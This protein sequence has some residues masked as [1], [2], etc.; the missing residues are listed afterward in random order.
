MKLIL[1]PM[2]GVLDP[3]LRDLLGKIGGWDMAITEFIRVSTTVFPDHVFYRFCPE[4]H[5]NSK[6]LS[7]M[8]VRIQLL[9][10]DPEL[11]ALN[12]QRAVELGSFGIDLNFGCP[13]KTVNRSMGGAILLKDT[14]ILYDIVKA[15]RDAV[16]DHLPVTAKMRLGYEDDCKAMDNAVAMYEAGA[17]ELAIHAR[18]KTDGYRPPAYWKKIKPI[19]DALPINV[20][21]NGEI[22]TKEQAQQCQIES[23]CEDIMM[24][25]GA[26][27]VP[28]LAKVILGEDKMPWNEVLKWLVEYSQYEVSLELVSYYPN[29]LKQWLT[30][31]KLAYPEAQILFDQ[32]KRE[33][34]R[35]SITNFVRENLE[36]IDN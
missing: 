19:A 23:G 3:P 7:G 9:G 27:A 25:R 28:N 10:N 1:A 4:L 11:V 29:R 26:L 31:L 32:I 30:F 8:P 12:A 17:S 33:K 24:G 16:P 20:I 5:N 18:T 36:K 21:A 14:Q 2:E 34:S 13:A 6:T 15:V 35:E 22:W